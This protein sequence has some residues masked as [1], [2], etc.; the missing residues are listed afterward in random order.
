MHAT[1]R[2]FISH[3][4]H[5]FTQFVSS[6]L[7]CEQALS[8]LAGVAGRE[9]RGPDHPGELDHRIEHLAMFAIS[10]LK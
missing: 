5:M 8:Q 7:A 2:L 6:I 4:L 1:T 3:N 10:E 9:E